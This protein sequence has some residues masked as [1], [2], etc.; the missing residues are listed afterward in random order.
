MSE[1]CARCGE[2]GEDR[3][4]LWMACFYAMNELSVPFDR[5]QIYGEYLKLQAIEKR[6][7]F[8]EG[9]GPVVEYPIY[10]LPK[11]SEPQKYNFFT[12]RVCKS[13]RADWLDA[14]QSWFKSINFKHDVLSPD[15]GIFVHRNGAAVEITEE[16]WYRQ[17]PGREPVRIKKES[18]NV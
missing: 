10:D 18:K 13:C 7:L 6:N 11:G 17:N 2:E 5:V 12:L 1:K 4:T 16:E 8:P 3:R 15:S 14:I 9:R